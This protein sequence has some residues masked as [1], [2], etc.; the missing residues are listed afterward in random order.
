M[1]LHKMCG[2]SVGLVL[3]DVVQEKCSHEVRKWSDIGSLCRQGMKKRGDIF[4]SQGVLHD[5]LWLNKGP[6]REG[7]AV[8]DPC[9]SRSVQ[10]HHVCSV[11]DPSHWQPIESFIFSFCDILQLLLLIHYD[12]SAD[13]YRGLGDGMCCGLGSK[14]SADTF[15]LTFACNMEDSKRWPK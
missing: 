15:D 2:E 14:R 5:P 1:A 4:W 6:F 3:Q 13:G 7:K 10:S 12:R 9:V 11:L 8:Y